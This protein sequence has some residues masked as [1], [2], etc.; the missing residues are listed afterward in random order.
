MNMK[1]LEDLE[2]KEIM[3]LLNKC[4]MTHDGMWF[5]HCMDELGME[6][7]NLLN[8]RAIKTLAP[9]EVG[10]LKRTVGLEKIASFEELKHFFNVAADL[11]IPDFMGA[12]FTFPEENV[13]HVGMKPEK[14]FA[15]KGMQKLGVIKE[16]QCGVI[17]RLECWF[18]ALGLTYTVSPEAGKCSMHFEGECS[19]D[20]G[21]TF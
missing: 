5:Y 16:Y 10:R 17:Y 19:R 4:W 12:M 21:F 8:K 20:F 11:F 3:V 2:K 14:C 1:L 6:K 18:N 13:F 15:Y 7:A 9:I